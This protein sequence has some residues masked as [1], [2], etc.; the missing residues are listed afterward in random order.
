ML[1]IA[2]EK[3]AYQAFVNQMS[4]LSQA[5]ESILVKEPAFKSKKKGGVAS[6]LLDRKSEISLSAANRDSSHIALDFI[7]RDQFQP[8]ILHWVN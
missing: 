7:Y 1:L 8:A 4:R 3:A 5:I 6:T 2:I